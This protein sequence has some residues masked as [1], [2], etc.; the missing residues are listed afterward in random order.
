MNIF[1]ILSWLAVVQAAVVSSGVC[2]EFNHHVRPAPNMREKL[3]EI[4]SDCGQICDTSMA[5]TGKG[6]YYDFIEKKVDCK[7][8]FESPALDQTLMEDT[9]DGK[10]YT[11]PQFCELSRFLRNQ[12]T[13]NQRVKVK[14]NSMLQEGQLRK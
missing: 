6:K 4:M 9:L 5:P 7:A 10:E 8:L 2:P 1:L 3:Q 11:P 13:Y 14:K 12:F